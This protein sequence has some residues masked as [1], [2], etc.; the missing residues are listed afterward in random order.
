MVL[1]KAE[2]KARL[3]KPLHPGCRLVDADPV[4]KVTIIHGTCILPV[5]PE[6]DRLNVTKRYAIDQ[7]AARR[8]YCG[9]YHVR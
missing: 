1:S 5:L 2:I 7:I 3:Q 9:R 6:E 4:H 8:T